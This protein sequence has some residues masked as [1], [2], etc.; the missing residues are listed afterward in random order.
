MRILLLIC[1]L[2]SYTFGLQSFQNS[3]ALPIVF[4]HGI[5]TG[6]HVWYPMLRELS[7]KPSH[8][9]QLSFQSHHHFSIDQPV[10]KQ[11]NVWL[12]DY[13]TRDFIKETL[14]NDLT[15]YARRLT[16]AID[17]IKHISKSE[18][19]IIVGHSMGGL[20][21]RKYMT[22]SKKNWQSV[23]AVITLGSPHEGVL[24]SI[25][26]VGQLRDL[27]VGSDFLDTLD[28]DWRDM[29]AVE[30][31]K[32]FVVAAV[33]PPRG[34]KKITP[35]MTDLAGPGYVSLRSAMP[36]GEWRDVVG[37]PNRWTKG[38]FSIDYKLLLIDTHMGMLVNPMTLKLIKPL[39]F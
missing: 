8:T 3:A 25:P 4:V 14:K 5:G 19:V 10:S 33:K 21:V 16:Q 39:I 6:N 29:D 35:T 26:I 34:L 32:W 23:A 27:F 12:L 13:Y 7:L 37:A 22:L 28:Q 24:T 9:F 17:E 36:N 31:A 20:I 15:V 18:Q 11:T 30:P 38:S 1:F 2:F